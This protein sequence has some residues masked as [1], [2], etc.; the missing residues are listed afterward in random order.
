MNE[1][2][3]Q[4]KDVCDDKEGLNKPVVL[5]DVLP[6]NVKL[7]G[8]RSQHYNRPTHLNLSLEKD[9]METKSLPKS[10]VKCPPSSPPKSPPRGSPFMPLKC[11][12]ISSPVIATTTNT[13]THMSS[14]FTKFSLST[15][16]NIHSRTSPATLPRSSTGSS[17]SPQSPRRCSPATLPSPIRASPSIKPSLS[18]NSSMKLYTPKSSPNNSSTVSTPLHIS[19]LTTPIASP[20]SPATPSPP[21]LSSASSSPKSDYPKVVE[22]LQMIQRTEV[23][24]RVNATTTDAASQTDKEELPPT[25]LPTRKKLKEEIDCEKLAEDLLGHLPTSDRLKDLLGKNL[26]KNIYLS[27]ISLHKLKSR[28]Y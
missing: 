6:V 9:T 1:K 26:L 4:Q 13:S 11:T 20:K 19:P 27:E 17:P 5:P 15:V 28:I 21:P 10:P 23:V 25:P 16:N 7:L 3:K 24:L 8:S 14:S 12:S 22:G 18:P 2:Q